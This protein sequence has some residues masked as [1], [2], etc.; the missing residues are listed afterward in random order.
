MCVREKRA[1]DRERHRDRDRLNGCYWFTLLFYFCSVVVSY[2]FKIKSTWLNWTIQ[3]T[4]EDCTEVKY[5]GQSPKPCT[6][7]GRLLCVPSRQESR[8]VGK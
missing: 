8:L 4:R 1:R 6:N 3:S 7:P 2:I 5:R